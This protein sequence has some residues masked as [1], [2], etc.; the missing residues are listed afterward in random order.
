MSTPN[1]VLTGFMGT[2]KSEVGRLV[3]RKLG[4][5]FVD[6]D[7]LIEAREGRT[8]ADIFAQ[9]GEAYFRRVEAQIV[10]E[11]A[12]RT[13]LVIATGGG[14]L[15]SPENRE[16]MTATGIVIC[17]WADEDTLLRRL[18]GDETRPLLAR[19]DREEALRVLLRRRTPLYQQLPYH[20]DTT[21]KSVA[22]VADEVIALYTRVLSGESPRRRG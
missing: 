6:M 7:A 22:R 10:R 16:A 21:G 8:I 3:A 2:G 14:A 9:E 5:P 1:L 17:L 11:L 15:L 13:G 18:R 20:I 19:P 12:R 4:R